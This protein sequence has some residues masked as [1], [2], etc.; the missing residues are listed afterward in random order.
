V[1]KKKLYDV[2]PNVT[3]WRVLRK[4]LYLN[5]Y[6]LFTIQGVEQWIVSTILSKR[7]HITRY[8]VTFGIPS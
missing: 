4:R 3:V 2:I 8:T 5:A 6:A 1:F 7:F